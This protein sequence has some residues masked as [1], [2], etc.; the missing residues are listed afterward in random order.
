MF[1]ALI[2]A[3]LFVKRLP[4]C[5]SVNNNFVR[6]FDARK[7][8][9]GTRRCFLGV[10]R[11]HWPPGPPLRTHYGPGP[12]T[13]YGPVHG[14]PV[15]TPLRT[16]PQN[17]V[18][19]INKDSTSGLSNWLLVSLKFRVLESK[20]RSLDQ[21]ENGLSPKIKQNGKR[22]RAQTSR[23]LWAFAEASWRL[24]GL[25]STIWPRQRKWFCVMI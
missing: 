25:S 23:L 9:T 12:R 24:S 2:R 18:K 11:K 15:R 21:R 13:T 7:R 1:F 22:E 20:L 17:R 8:V 6:H 4:W 16:T 19:I 10:T 3:V 5:E 14:L